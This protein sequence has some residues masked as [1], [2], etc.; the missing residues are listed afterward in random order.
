MMEKCVWIHFSKDILYLWDFKKL[1]AIKFLEKDKG[2]IATL[3]YLSPTGYLP[4][5]QQELIFFHRFW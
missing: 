3:N 2:C 4:Q 5:E 1:P